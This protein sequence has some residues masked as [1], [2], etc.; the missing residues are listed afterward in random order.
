V[1]LFDPEGLDCISKCFLGYSFPRSRSVSPSE[2]VMLLE[3]G[4]ILLNSLCNSVMNALRASLI[5]SVPRFAQG[6]RSRI[7]EAL[8]T[9]PAAGPDSRIIAVT[10]GMRS[11][12]SESRC[13]V[14]LLLPEA[15]AL[16]LEGAAA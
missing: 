2:E 5:P 15:L 7:T 6:G 4:N 12:A 13:L 14:L 1:L 10:L 8:A 11:G 3:L 16:A 9:A